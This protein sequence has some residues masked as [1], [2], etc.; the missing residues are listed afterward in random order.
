MYTLYGK[1]ETTCDSKQEPIIRTESEKR[2]LS[3]FKFPEDTFQNEGLHYCCWID[4][5]DMELAEDIIMEE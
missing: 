5:L 2:S 1:K 4:Y 3:I